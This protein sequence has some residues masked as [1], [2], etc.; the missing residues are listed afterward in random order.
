[1]SAPTQ[2]DTPAPR[3]TLR[4]V[5]LGLFV[6]WQLIF[7]LGANVLE[8]IPH[9]PVERDELTDFRESNHLSSQSRGLLGWVAAPTDLW[10]EATGQYQVWWLFAPHVPTQ[11]TFLAVD[12]R[13]DDD[14]AL[15]PVA[16][17]ATPAPVRLLSDLE[18]A[19]PAVYFRWPGSRERQF[20]Y[21][22]RLA[23]HYLF[24]DE[25]EAASQIED[26]KPFIR[27]RV[28]RQWRSLRAYLRWQLQAF[29]REHPELPSPRQAVLSVRLYHIPP[30]GQRLPIGPVEVPLARWWIH[31]DGP[32][33]CLPIEVY[34]PF[35]R[36]FERLPKSDGVSP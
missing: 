26:W 33:D 3:P 21:E 20:H 12:L 32:A 30:A 36:R 4:Q 28:T 5:L 27:C 17:S 11:A 7:L 14:S 24:W 23:L 22:V 16:S 9:R 1:M 13:W 8:F 2:I 31:E 18:P 35:A 34:D 25:Q 10:A 19:D 6:V 15:A 29:Q